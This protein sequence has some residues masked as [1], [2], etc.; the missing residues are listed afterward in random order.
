MILKGG[1]NYYGIPIAVEGMEDSR[2]FREVILE[3][4]RDDMDF[5]QVEREVVAAAQRLQ[6]TNPDLGALVL[7]CTDLPPYAHSIQCVTGLPVFDLTT[8]TNMVYQASST[9]ALSGLYGNDRVNR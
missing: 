1:I 6:S 7:E 9:H 3:A 5:E 8:L 4:Q 2:E